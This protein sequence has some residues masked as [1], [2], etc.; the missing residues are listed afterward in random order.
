M[1]DE[2]GTSGVRLGLRIPGNAQAGG[3][4]GDLGADFTFEAG[5]AMHQQR[6]HK[7]TFIARGRN[8]RMIKEI[9]T[10][11]MHRKSLT[12]EPDDPARAVRAIK[13]V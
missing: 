3:V 5:T 6:I 12:Q 7:E 2:F 4:F 11:D 10:L 8:R 9:G 1:A 13:G